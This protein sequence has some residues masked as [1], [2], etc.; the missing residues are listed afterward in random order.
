MP[1]RDKAICHFHKSS[2]ALLLSRKSCREVLVTF[3]H[4]FN[5]F[6]VVPDVNVGKELVVGRGGSVHLVSLPVEQLEVPDLPQVVPLLL[7]TSQHSLPLLPQSLNLF[8]C[9]LGW[10]SC[11]HLL[12]ERDQRGELVLLGSNLVPH[13]GMFVE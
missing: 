12:T 7:P 11:V 8:L 3:Q 9:L 2:H 6:K 13:L 4:S 1:G 5:I 10:L